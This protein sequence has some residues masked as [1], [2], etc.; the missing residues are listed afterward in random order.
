[1]NGPQ[2]KTEVQSRMVLLLLLQ[3]LHK[4][5]ATISEVLVQFF[6]EAGVRYAFGVCGAGI[7][8]FLDALQN[9]KIKVIHNRHESGSSFCATE[10]SLAL[11]QPVLVYV[12][13][14]PGLTNV[15]TGIF[16]ARFE[17]AKVILVSASSPVEKYGM[18]A[19]QETS[20]FTFPQEGLFTSGVLFHYATTLVNASQLSQ[21]QRQIQIGINSPQSF[22]AHIS[23]PADVQS[24]KIQN[25]PKFDILK[26]NFLGCTASQEEI[27]NCS[28]ILQRGGPFAIWVGFGARNSSHEVLRLAESTG[29]AV[30]CTARGK[31][32]FPEDHPQFVGVTGIAGHDSVLQYMEKV[33]PQVTLVLGTRLHE[34]SSSFDQ[35]MVP[36]SGFIHVDIDHCIPGKNFAKVISI[37]SE[38]KLFLQALLR[39]FRK[40]GSLM[41]VYDFPQVKFPLPSV[42][43]G[44][45]RPEILMRGIQKVIVDGSDSIVMAE[46]GNSLVWAIHYLK[47]TQ[48]NRFRASIF[49]GAMGHFTCGVVG[50]SLVQNKKAVAIVGDGAMLMQN[51][52]HTA[53]QQKIQAVWIVLNDA[54]YNIIRQGQTKIGLNC[55]N[56]QF[57][58][59]DFVA[60]AKSLGAGGLMLK[61]ESKIETVL[62][63]AMEMDGPVVVD[64][65]IDPE[66]RAP[67]GQKII[68]QS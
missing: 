41:N 20:P 65:F 23:L 58:Q 62:K 43:S 55:R 18:G 60:L 11:N 61:K 56:T 34:H 31:G 51:E 67:I 25:P 44:K 36:R 6:Y 32:I 68:W 57:D 42:N 45:I 12:T 29:A 37:H 16:G 22:V 59:V 47:F 24:A 2:T 15:L 17:G 49:F 3:N 30:M 66:I 8:Y 63:A 5:A 35:K 46:P 27:E 9:S 38:I 19:I 64:V 10:A 53:V 1:M 54:A 7:A 13:V 48:P 40:I 4:T 26:K 39:Y 14:G 28:K 21:I 33:Q 52:I 50:A